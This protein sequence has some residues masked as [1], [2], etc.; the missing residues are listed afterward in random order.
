MTNEDDRR[1]AYRA[2]IE[3]KVEYKRL[4]TF[5]ADYTRNISRGGTFIGTDKPVWYQYGKFLGRLVGVQWDREG[6]EVWNIRFASPSLGRSFATRQNVNDIVARA[7]PVTASLVIG[8]AI[9]W[10][11]IALPLGIL[12]ALRP[13]SLLDRAGMVFVLIGI[14]A[15]PVWI[16]LLLIYFVG[17]KAG[18]TP[19]GGYCD[20]VN[21]STDC[22]GPV[23]WA[24]ALILPWITFA[25]LFAA[26]H[27]DASCGASSCPIDLAQHEAPSAGDLRMDL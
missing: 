26:R 14:S 23:D 21:P 3:L 25:V 15:H 4:N 18:L 2:P 10:L 12:S 11:L 1:L 27:A 5:F 9:V 20:M 8:G 17:Y 16:G 22:G 7:A 24:H 6:G 19:L 13:R